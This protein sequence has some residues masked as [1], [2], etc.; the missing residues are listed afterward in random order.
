M[1]ALSQ[2]FHVEESRLNPLQ[3]ETSPSRSS[4]P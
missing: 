2:T 4:R 3:Y 1:P